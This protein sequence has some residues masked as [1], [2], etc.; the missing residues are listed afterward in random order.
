M[1]AKKT[2]DEQ[3]DQRI[4]QIMNAISDIMQKLMKARCAI[5]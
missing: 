2:R 4:R 5:N 3:V 1:V